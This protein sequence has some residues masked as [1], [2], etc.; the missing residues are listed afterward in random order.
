MLRDASLVIILI[1]STIVFST[2]S[3][4]QYVR[5]DPN[6]FS[7]QELIEDVLFSSN[8]VENVQILESISGNFNDGMLSF[9]F[10][11]SIDSNF[12]FESGLVLSTGR[13]DNVDGPNDTLS[14]DDAPGW[15]GDADLENSL[16][17]SGTINATVMRFTFTPN[18][19]NISF[20]YIF[21]SEEYQENNS[22]TC[23]YSDA[24]AFLIRPVGSQNYENIAVIPGTQTP[25]LVTTVRP[26]IPGACEAL[27]EEF[28]GQFNGTDAPINFNGQTA[29]LTAEAEVI[30]NQDYEIKLV[31]ADE[32]NYRY[33]SAVFL[34]ANSFNVGFNL[35]IDRTGSNSL[36]ETE[37]LQLEIPQNLQ[38]NPITWLYNGTPIPGETDSTYLV[39]EADFGAG[40]YSAKVD[41][42]NGCIATDNIEINYE[43]PTSAGILRL[44]QC[45]AEDSD[46]IFNLNSIVP[47]LNEQGF[48]LIPLNYFETFAAAETN[49]NPINDPETFISSPG[50]NVF[51]RLANPFGCVSISEIE[52]VTEFTQFPEV[53]IETCSPSDEDMVSFDL[54]STVNRI[55]NESN[56]TQGNISIFRSEAEAANAQ[57]PI[58]GTVIR[59]AKENLPATYYAR[60]SNSLGCRGLI[61]LNF[62]ASSQVEVD[63]PV[64]DVIFCR[65]DNSILLDSG[66][67][68]SFYDFTWSDGRTS[69]RIS[70]TEPGMYEVLIDLPNAPDQNCSALKTFNVE[71]SSQAEIDYKLLGSVGSYSVEIIA[72]GEGEYEFS[73]NGSSFQQNPVFTEVE[74][75]N[76]TLVR[77]ILGCGVTQ[78]SFSSLVFPEFFTPNQDGINDFW[79][80]EGLS[81]SS[82]NLISLQIFDRYGKLISVL[83]SNSRGWNGTYNGKEMPQDDYWFRANFENQASIQGNFTLKR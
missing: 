18:A 35:G 72:N 1:F 61:P 20:R 80:P 60:V 58:S 68:Q 41:L 3:F 25:V 54:F 74:A 79:F 63:D 78:L 31:I 46:V 24:F 14:D 59:I 62:D 71:I 30:P 5:T 83:N 2:N 64:V 48:N 37:E 42:G 73:L 52:L 50:E 65:G 56:I 75:F 13:L 21:A 10:F 82:F 27:N 55:Q 33:D 28:F 7:S 44:A 23:I 77:D 15:T 66:F 67:D 40:T 9:G 53:S 8:C 12:P 69:S 22:N 11:E 36:C 43:S 81:A 70:V 49:S 39:S 16:G 32:Q 19:Q 51:V 29:I 47:Q 26:E 76:T 57:N 6:T 4:A 45:T 17:I 34:E 38:A